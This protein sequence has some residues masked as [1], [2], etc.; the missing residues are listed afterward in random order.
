[1]AEEIPTPTQ[2]I[3]RYPGPNAF[4]DTPIDHQLFFGRDQEIGH[5][6][7]F[8]QRNNAVVVYGGMGA[9]KTSMLRAGLFPALRARGFLPL[10][11]DLKDGT[12][13]QPFHGLIDAVVEESPESASYF[14]K[15]D[16]GEWSIFSF[17]EEVEFEGES[18]PLAPVLVIDRFESLFPLYPP[19]KRREI[20]RDLGDLITRKF[21]VEHGAAERDFRRDAP[22]V[23][24]LLSISQEHLGALDEFADILPDAMAY[25]VPVRPL[26]RNEARKALMAPGPVELG[27]DAT[28]PFE[29]ERA[30]ADPLL[31]LARI[32]SPAPGD[33][34]MARYDGFMLQLLGR[35][36]E[37]WL[38]ANAAGFEDESSHV[39]HPHDNGNSVGN[40]TSADSTGGAMPRDPSLALDVQYVRSNLR[41]LLSRYYQMRLE[42]IR[43]GR[44]RRRCRHM[45]ESSLFGEISQD[46]GITARIAQHQ[47]GV[48][49][50]DLDFLVENHLL[51]EKAGKTGFEYTL[52]HDSL[53]PAIR[54]LRNRLQRASLRKRGFAVVVLLGLVALAAN[55]YPYKRLG[56]QDNYENITS[57]DYAQ[58]YA[59]DSEMLENF[60]LYKV[61]NNPDN[62]RP[63]WQLSGLM[64]E[65]GRY[66]EA[67]EIVEAI[68]QLENP[69]LT[70]LRR[71]LLILDR[72]ERDKEAFRVLNDIEQL[73]QVSASGNSEVD[74]YEPA[75]WAELYARRA[76]AFVQQGAL[77]Q[78]E[79]DLERAL[80]HYTRSEDSEVIRRKRAGALVSLGELLLDQGVTQ[81]ARG[82]FDAALELQPEMPRALA[83]RAEATQDLENTVAALE[84][85]NEL[86]EKQP[87]NLAAV[88]Q[89]VDLLL[90]LDQPGKAL[91][92]LNRLHERYPENVKILLQRG[93]IYRKLGLMDKALADYDLALRLEP[94]NVNALLARADASLQIQDVS[95]ALE[96]YTRVIQLDPTIPKAYGNRGIILRRQGELEQALQDYSRLIILNPDDPKAHYLR[97]NVHLDLA[98]Y[99]EAAEDFQ[100]SVRLDPTNARAWNNLGFANTQLENYETAIENFTEAIAIDPSNAE[101]YSNRGFAIYYHNQDATALADFHRA[102]IL[103][104]KNPENFIN[105]GNYYLEIEDAELARKDFT[106]AIELDGAAAEAYR[107]RALAHEKLRDTEKAQ[108]DLKEYEKLTGSS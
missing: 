83:L 92:D 32:A 49:Q 34:E 73:M 12:P 33:G 36:I 42:L 99:Q 71:K 21:P 68:E 39:E 108:A 43:N 20:I 94:D 51:R 18:A 15:M 53:I 85:L 6:I 46:K 22:R 89:R 7:R 1:M 24:L 27:A 90:Q 97:G 30:V 52:I 65:Q 45:L 17:F 13:Q 63:L 100:A 10:S 58:M 105:R 57:A 87:A 56:M 50:S 4:A 72:L 103:D 40:E 79:D 66:G 84:D 2:K 75:A 25:R 74:R 38:S 37:R 29:L 104:P 64:E 81:E 5:V 102:V 70:L 76:Q 62:P 77:P 96:D 55:L 80:L 98:N 61:R 48:S 3:R 23:K 60:L 16:S 86:L 106:Q 31:S 35:Y 44:R 67:L 28:A 91:P 47:F 69:S 54:E 59:E 95:S 8:L 107:G 14:E 93:E 78:A 19:T 41:G 9:G 26:G 82:Y 88:R 11:V 101:A